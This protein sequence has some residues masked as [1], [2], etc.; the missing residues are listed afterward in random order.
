MWKFFVIFSPY[1]PRIGEDFGVV[2]SFD[3]KPMDG[4][5][6]GAGAHTNFSTEDMRKPGGMKT[7]G[8]CSSH[9]PPPPT[10]IYPPSPDPSPLSPPIP[11]PTETISISFPKES[12]NC[13]ALWLYRI[14][15]DFFSMLLKLLL[16]RFFSDWKLKCNPLTDGLHRTIFILSIY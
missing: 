15:T 6:N 14:T 4:D 13:L 9:P 11:P 2:V 3:P 16:K 8:E 12:K 5:W 1:F 7:I 10:Y